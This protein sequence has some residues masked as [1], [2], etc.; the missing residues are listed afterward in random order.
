[1]KKNKIGVIGLGYVGLPVSVCF[2]KKYKVVGFD[3]N[4]SRVNELNKFIDNTNEVSKKELKNSLS[5]NLKISNNIKAIKDCNVYIIT[6]PTPI[7][8]DKS[9]DLNLLIEATRK[10]GKILKKG[11][12][13]IYE[14]TVYPGC[15]EEECVPVLEKT[16]KLIYNSDFFCG[17]S[18]ERINPGDKNHRIESIVKVTSG[19][20]NDIADK[21]DKLYSSVIQAGTHKAQSIKIAEAAKVIENAQRDINIAFVN[22]LARIFNKLNIDTNDV[23]DAASTKWNFLNFRPGLVGGH[24]IGVDPFY[25]AD[26]A[27]KTG[28]DANIILSGRK[29]NDE[30]GIYV[31]N[32]MIH[33]LENSGHKKKKNRILILGVTFKENCPDFRNTK[34]VDIYNFLNDINYAVDIY[35]PLVDNKAFK[36]EYGIK[37]ISDLN[38]KYYDGIILAVAHKN[39][40]NININNLV[41]SKESVIYDLKG[42]LENKKFINRL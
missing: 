41:K 19:S 15:T 34:V 37:L 29:L 25:L 13:V 40:K 26:K 11:D 5:K 39:F 42:F 3:I 24:C 17:Y 21:I 35:D 31:A 28:Y 22:E 18:P 10:I 8:K 12:I 38:N 27:K 16:S 4:K 9:P 36:E 20:N 30:M 33:F 23:L 32:Q 7:K 2:A 6:V 14:S 1:M